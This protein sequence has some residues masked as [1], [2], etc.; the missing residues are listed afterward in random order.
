M[1][2][3]A[4]VVLASLLSTSFVSSSDFTDAVIEVANNIYYEKFY[5]KTIIADCDFGHANPLEMCPLPMF[6]SGGCKMGEMFSGKPTKCLGHAKKTYHQLGTDVPTS[7]EDRWYRSAD[8]TIS[9]Q[10]NPQC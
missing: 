7:Y 3:I 9:I 5:Q 4:I 10:R 6:G 8:K 1:L 2:R